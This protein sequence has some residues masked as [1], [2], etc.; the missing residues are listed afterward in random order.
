MQDAKRK[1]FIFLFLAFVFALI[2]GWTFIGYVQTINAEMGEMSTYYVAKKD[3]APRVP[4][5]TDDFE[6]VDIPA[7][8]MPPNLVTEPT[9]IEGMVAVVSLAK[10]DALEKNALKPVTASAQGADSRLVRV[11]A[12][13]RIQFDSPLEPLDRVDIIVSYRSAKQPVTEVFMRDVPVAT[14]Y[15]GASSDPMASGGETAKAMTAISVE[16][17]LEEARRLIQRLN[18][19]DHIRVLKANAGNAGNPSKGTPTEN[20][21][22]GNPP[23]GNPS[24]G[25]GGGGK[26]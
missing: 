7:R 23:S 24:S 9:S 5:K 17:T 13:D 4:L 6:A 25:K 22:P 26:G 2:A 12:S 8:F 11:M 16:V 14:V 10:G 21:P 15:E 19:S 1:A 20:P 3:I 18:Y